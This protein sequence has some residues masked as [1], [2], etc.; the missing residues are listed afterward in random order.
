MFRFTLDEVKVRAR[1][2]CAFVNKEEA[3]T[4]AGFFGSI[5]RSVKFFLHDDPI[6]NRIIIYMVILFI[7]ESE[8]KIKCKSSNSWISTSLVALEITGTHRFLGIRVRKILV[9]DP[10]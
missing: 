4:F 6:S 7:S 1:L 3:G 5:L 2:R 9:N 8:F 10:Q